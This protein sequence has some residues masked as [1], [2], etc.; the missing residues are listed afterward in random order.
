MQGVPAGAPIGSEKWHEQKAGGYGIFTKG[1]TKN[2]YAA[3]EGVRDDLDEPLAKFAAK[4]GF[5]TAIKQLKALHGDQK[6]TQRTMAIALH[7]KH[8]D[9]GVSNWKAVL[10]RLKTG[11]KQPPSQGPSLKAAKIHVMQMHKQKCGGLFPR[12]KKR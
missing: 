12:R 5:S 6:E 7:K 1:P 8:P 9:R 4:P 11:N 2:H 3:I 10:S